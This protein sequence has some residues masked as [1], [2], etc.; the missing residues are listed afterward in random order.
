[1]KLLPCF[2]LPILSLVSADK[3]PRLKLHPKDSP[4]FSFGHSENYAVLFHDEGSSQVYIGGRGVVRILSFTD[5]E[6]KQTEIHLTAEDKTKKDCQAKYPT[7]KA[8][9][10]N[11]IRV[12]QRLNRTS[13]I[14]CGT[15][16]GSPKCWFLKN[17]GKVLPGVSIKG[18]K[19][20]SALPSDPSVT[21]SA[22]GNLYSALSQEKS[23]I[24]RSYGTLKHIKTEDKWLPNAE[25]VTAARLSPESEDSDAIYFFFNEVNKAAGLES[26]PFKAWLGRVC[27]GDEGA[28]NVLV[29]SWTTFLKARLVCGNS[30]DPRRFDR[31]VDAFVVTGGHED[32]GLIYGIFANEWGSTAVC[33]Y[34]T[35]KV[36][37]AFAS[38]KLKGLTGS[39]S[40][41]TPG[42]CISSVATNALARHILTTMKD[43]PELEAVIFPYEERPLYTLPAGESYTRV[44]A[45]RLSDLSLNVN[46]ILFLGTDKGKLHKVLHRGSQTIILAEFSP[47]EE[48]SPITTLDVDITTGHI[49]L[50]TEN[51]ATRLP[52]ADCAGYGDTCWECVLGRDPHCGWDLSAKKCSFTVNGTDSNMLQS[53]DA[54]NVTAC[55]DALEGHSPDVDEKQVS[56]L[57]SSY[58]YFPCPVRSHH[59]TYTWSKDT[60]KFHRCTIDGEVCILRFG[61]D[62]PMEA[63]LYTC[64][65][66]EE[67]VKK[68]IT[69]YRLL[70]GGAAGVPRLALMPALFLQLVAISVVFI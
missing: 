25:F 4:V 39:V 9:C 11:F 56:V 38:S 5:S 18:E 23:V 70:E 14:I 22:D 45:E 7:A 43:Y 47:F 41:H 69:R 50:G 19:M 28:K 64:S 1:M 51:E 30:S 49:Y 61:K 59:A 63:G 40:P 33:M 21:I 35:E 3:T 31:L 12:I 10:E 20:V 37:E 57:P 17:D 60:S 32:G 65:A 53:L 52:L 36:T 13:T 67:T 6:V 15:N 27:K 46:T 58:V 34:S 16:A 48:E 26:E 54:T 24:Q 68:E 66:T 55:G 62:T 44:V 8:E 29:D 42:K 2:L